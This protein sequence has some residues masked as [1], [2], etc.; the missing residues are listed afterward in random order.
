MFNVPPQT[1][2]LIGVGEGEN[3]EITINAVRNKKKTIKRTKP[4][5]DV[6][7]VFIFVVVFTTL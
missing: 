5:R 4:E 7:N 6:S 1:E 3:R 2:D